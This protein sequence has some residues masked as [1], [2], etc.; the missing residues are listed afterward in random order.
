MKS[1]NL[2]IVALAVNYVICNFLQEEVTKCGEKKKTHLYS[3]Q[4]VTAFTLST[5]EQKITNFF[6]V[7]P[8]H[9]ISSCYVY[10]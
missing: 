8:S 5:I 2:L 7:K 4:K 6:S 1:Q 3:F 9:Y 10:H